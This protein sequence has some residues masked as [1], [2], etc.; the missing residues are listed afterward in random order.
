MPFAFL[1]ARFLY[2]LTKT[3]RQPKQMTYISKSSMP[4][5]LHFTY[6]MLS[7]IMYRHAA[8]IT[9]QRHATFIDTSI[10]CCHV[11]V[12]RDIYKI[13]ADDMLIPGI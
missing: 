12:E 8:P 4:H 10:Y 3:R 9:R 13:Y 11:N 7:A 5:V 2:K 1:S 6:Y